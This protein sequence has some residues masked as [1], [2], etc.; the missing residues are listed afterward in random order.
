M[1]RNLVWDTA[2]LESFGQEQFDRLKLNQVYH[3]SK[4]QDVNMPGVGIFRNRDVQLM[5]TGRS[6][7]NGRSTIAELEK[8]LDPKRFIRIHRST[9]LNADWIKEISSLPGG[10]LNVR[11][12]DGKDTDLSVARDR[13]QH[14]K[15]RLGY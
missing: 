7:R 9:L 11:L 14:F 4:D 1:E 12:K 8:K 15:I 10:G 2:M 3:T 6:Y 13:A 5:W